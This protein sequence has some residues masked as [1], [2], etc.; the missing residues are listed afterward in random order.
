MLIA[1]PGPR[2]LLQ[3]SRWHDNQANLKTRRV[4]TLTKKVK[5]FEAAELLE[6]VKRHQRIANEL[7]RNAKQIEER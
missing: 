7:R 5:V 3:V 6:E 2:D 4:K 1:L